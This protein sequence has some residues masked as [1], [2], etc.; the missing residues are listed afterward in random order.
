MI[1][2]NIFQIIQ[3]LVKIL[4]VQLSVVLA[5]R[6]AQTMAYETPVEIFQGPSVERNLTILC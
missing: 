1:N 4:G 5:P 6:I 2:S 3:I